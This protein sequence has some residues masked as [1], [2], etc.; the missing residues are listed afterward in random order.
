MVEVVLEEYKAV[1]AIGDRGGF[2]LRHVNDAV[3]WRSGDFGLDHVALSFQRFRLGQ[4][5]LASE[6]SP[7]E[8]DPL[9]EL[10]MAEVGSD[11][12]V[13]LDIEVCS[14][15]VVSAIRIESILHKSQ[16]T[17]E[18]CVAVSCC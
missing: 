4:W 12:Q 10:L 13:Q 1:P 16:W 5:V 3:D 8:Q 14:T 6:E 18:C 15:L 17:V 9:T 11:G 7:G 2:V